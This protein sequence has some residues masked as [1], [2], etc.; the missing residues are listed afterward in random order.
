M[1][2]LGLLVLP[3]AAQEK[4]AEKA[5][6]AKQDPAVAEQIKQFRSAISE[7][8]GERDAEASNLIDKL[9]VAYPGMHPKD[10]AEVVKTLQ[11]CLL[12]SKIRRDTE[13][14]TLF[15]GCAEALGRMGTEGAEILVKAC[16]SPK[17][18][19][20]EWISLRGVFVRNVGRAKDLRQVDFLVDVASRDPD[21]EVM[22]AA[23]EALGNYE[24][25]ELPVRK[26]IAKELIKKL[27]EVHGQA[28]ANIDPNDPQV[29]RSK[30]Q[31]TAISR[32]WNT[33]LSKLTKQSINSPEEWQHFWNKNKDKDWDKM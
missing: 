14:T 1:A 13:H 17:F 8:K 24:D 30:Q 11:E 33:T 2:V 28:L 7:R 3:A 18:K 21:D 32:D 16:K 23:G 31:L 9:L 29:K 27:S 20:Q 6:P 25:A 26:E 5:A 10:Q 19:G 22:K 12:S 4:E 15:V